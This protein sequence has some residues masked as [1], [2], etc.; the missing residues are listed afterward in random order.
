YIAPNFQSG[1]VPYH[2]PPDGEIKVGS[3]GVAI[4]QLMEPMRFAL[5]VP[6]GA[7]PPGGF[8]IAIYSHG[9]GGDFKS[10]IDDGTAAALNAQGLAVISTDQVLHGPRNPSGNEETDFFN[11]A[12]PYAIRDNVLQGAADAWSQLRLAQGLSIPGGG[13]TITFDSSK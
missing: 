2:N 6:N 5:T 3:D 9:T 8:P 4:V 12:N 10:F 1:E 7:V 11:I 13:R